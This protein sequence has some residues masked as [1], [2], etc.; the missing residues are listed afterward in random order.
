MKYNNR[1]KCIRDMYREDN[2]IHILVEPDKDIV[3][4]SLDLTIKNMNI[5]LDEV[6]DE[7]IVNSNSISYSI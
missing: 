4:V 5:L 7:D 6:L 2:N 3:P 1:M